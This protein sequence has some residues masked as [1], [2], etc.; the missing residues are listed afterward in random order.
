M[1][2]VA[3]VNASSAGTLDDQLAARLIYYGMATAR[4]H[5]VKRSTI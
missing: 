5:C 3:G 2:F 4:V 1:Q